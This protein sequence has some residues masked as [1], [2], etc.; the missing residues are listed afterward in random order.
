MPE[1]IT[2][3]VW[4]FCWGL[5][6]ASGVLGGTILGLIARLPHRAIAAIMSFGA[7]VLLSAASIKI[8]SEALIPHPA[9]R[10]RQVSLVFGYA[11]HPLQPAEV[12]EG[13]VLALD[14]YTI[15]ASAFAPQAC[16]ALLRC[17]RRPHV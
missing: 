6:A 7:G 10:S 17:L 13:C 11:P 5:A 12:R 15:S 2:G 1:G 16:R 14:A 8:A 3:A 4:A 9:Q